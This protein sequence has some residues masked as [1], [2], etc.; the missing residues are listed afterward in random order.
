MKLLLGT[1]L[2]LLTTGCAGSLE[3][4]RARSQMNPRA[5]SEARGA[6]PGVARRAGHSRGK[7]HA[8]LNRSRIPE[9]LG[10][11]SVLALD[12]AEDRDTQGLARSW[13]FTDDAL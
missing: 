8:N 13:E 1:V 3:S 12:T 9:P 4:A 11:A 2:V 6:A 5:A 10:A 7:N